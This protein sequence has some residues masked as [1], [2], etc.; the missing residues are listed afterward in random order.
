MSQAGPLAIPL[1][2]A[3]LAQPAAA[4][5]SQSRTQLSHNSNAGVGGTSTALGSAHAAN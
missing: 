5:Y 2:G 1:L 3:K 4:K